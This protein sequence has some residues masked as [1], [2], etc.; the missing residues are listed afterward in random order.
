MYLPTYLLLL[1][2]V[3]LLWTDPAVAIAPT[4]FIGAF[5]SLAGL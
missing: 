5:L 2:V 3:L 4:L 1:V